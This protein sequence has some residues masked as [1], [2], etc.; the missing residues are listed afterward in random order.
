MT[1][2]LL[3]PGDVFASAN[4]QAL[5]R[6]INIVQ[7]MYSDDGHS[8]YGHAGIILDSSGNTF[9]ALWTIKRSHIEA[10]TG[11]KFLVARWKGMNQYLFA[12]GFSK[13]VIQ[14]GQWYPVARLFLHL[15]HLPKV[16]IRNREVCSELACH[17]LIAAGA[18]MRSGANWFGVTPD[19]LVDE[20]RISRHFDIIYEG[21]L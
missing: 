15:L 18:V 3:R 16:H 6:V 20:W 21:I 14:E 12:K 1:I 17:F 11:K 4:P 9:E 19:E 10:Y 2:P 5:G 8:E 13:V 7:R